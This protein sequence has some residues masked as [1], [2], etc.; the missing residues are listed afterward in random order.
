MN[1]FQKHSFYE[2]VRKAMH[3]KWDPIGIGAYSVKIGEY[4]GYISGL[5]D[6]LEKNLDQQKIFDYLWTIET[7]SMGMEGNKENTKKFAI[8]LSE[9]SKKE[10]GVGM[11]PIDALRILSLVSWSMLYIGFQRGWVK[12]SDIADYATNQLSADM[13][14]GDENIAVL[15]SAYSLDDSEVLDLLLKVGGDEKYQNSIEK[16]RLAKLVALSES[17][18]CEEEKLYKLQEL[19]AEFDYPE[20]MAPCSVYS[21]DSVDP[22]VAMSELILALKNKFS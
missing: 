16:W 2:Q 21:K 22:L 6:L 10:R 4:D 11:K 7:V 13:D 5:C 3:Y 12:K 1:E 17:V 20:D 19:Y 18:L 15:A 8:W 9:L 14:N